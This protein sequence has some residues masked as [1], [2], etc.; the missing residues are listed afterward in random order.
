MMECQHAHADPFSHF[1]LKKNLITAMLKRF[2]SPLH[3]FM[4]GFFYS[5]IMSWTTSVGETQPTWWVTLFLQS[6]TLQLCQLM[7]Q[8]AGSFITRFISSV[9]Q[10]MAP[11]CDSLLSFFFLLTARFQKTLNKECRTGSFRHNVPQG[12]LLQ[13]RR[14]TSIG[15]SEKTGSAWLKNEIETGKISILLEYFQQVVVLMSPAT[16]QQSVH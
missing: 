11:F 8:E 15:E 4:G 1:F 10:G 3:L 6:I 12:D 2:E 16:I 13:N 9:P 5:F 14:M 7:F